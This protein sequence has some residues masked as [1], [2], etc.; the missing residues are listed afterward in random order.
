MALDLQDHPF[1]LLE[2]LQYYA[3]GVLELAGLPPPVATLPLPAAQQRQSLSGSAN[4]SVTTAPLAVTE[5][6]PDVLSVLFCLETAFQYGLKDIAFF[7]RTMIYHFFAHLTDCLPNAAGLRQLMRVLKEHAR[8]DL[9]RGRLFL[10][11]ALNE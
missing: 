6:T 11:L 4:G 2:H 3:D 9:G 5:A 1:L 7:G 10:R 8:T